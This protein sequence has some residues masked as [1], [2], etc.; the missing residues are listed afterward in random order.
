MIAESLFLFGVLAVVVAYRK[1]VDMQMAKPR[2]REVYNAFIARFLKPDHVISLYRTIY[3]KD[4]RQVL[5]EQQR[6]HELFHIDEQWAR[7]PYTFPVRIGAD[8]AKNGY[9]GSYFENAARRAAGQPE[10]KKRR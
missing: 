2:G 5:T 6:E 3:K 4:R 9:D 1:F 10:R 8:Y 7:W